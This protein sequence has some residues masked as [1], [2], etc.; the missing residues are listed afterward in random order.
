MHSHDTLAG[1]GGWDVDI[2]G[3]PL[4]CPTQQVCRRQWGC[5]ESCPSYCWLGSSQE[6]ILTSPPLDSRLNSL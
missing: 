3:E 2:F 6:P 5:A 4:L 1:A